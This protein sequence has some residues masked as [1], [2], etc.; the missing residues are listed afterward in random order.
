M[1]Y[2]VH[3]T[4]DSATHVLLWITDHPVLVQVESLPGGTELSFDYG[5]HY[6][7]VAADRGACA[8]ASARDEERLEYVA[9]FVHRQQ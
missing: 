1:F 7:A 2:A 9:Q 8:I 3:A 4:G 6:S 5:P